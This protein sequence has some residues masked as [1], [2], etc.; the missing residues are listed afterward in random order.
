M[1]TVSLSSTAKPGTPHTRSGA[2]HVMITYFCATLV[3][4]K[5]ICVPIASGLTLCYQHSKKPAW[6]SSARATTF[7]VILAC[8]SMVLSVL[9]CVVFSP[10]RAKNDTQDKKIV[11]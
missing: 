7:G 5:A 4:P 10:R 11:I 9:W 6:L 8:G 3:L 1:G 2:K